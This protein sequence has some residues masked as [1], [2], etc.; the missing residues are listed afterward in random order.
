ML[1]IS[2]YVCIRMHLYTIATFTDGMILCI[3]PLFTIGCSLCDM[4][5]NG[6]ISLAIYI[7]KNIM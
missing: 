5:F 4:S 1:I 7:Y 2:D 3:C 6:H